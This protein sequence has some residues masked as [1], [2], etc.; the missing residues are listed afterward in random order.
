MNARF[1]G[2]VP[3]LRAFSRVLGGQLHLKAAMED[4][5]GARE[6]LA[7][8]YIH[9]LL[10]EYKGL[11]AHAQSGDAALFALTPDDLVA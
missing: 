8:F 2:A 5:G 6:R 7:Q 9:R 3:Y 11:L 4:Q 1:A 10:P